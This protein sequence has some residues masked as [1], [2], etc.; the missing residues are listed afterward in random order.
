MKD[1]LSFCL[2]EDPQCR[3]DNFNIIENALNEIYRLSI[4]PEVNDIYLRSVP[5][6]VI[7]IFTEDGE[8]LPDEDSIPESSHRQAE[9]LKKGD[10]LLDVYRVEADPIATGGMGKIWR[11][12]HTGWDID[13]A[14][15]RPYPKL[16]KNENQK[17]NFIN[18]CEAWINLGLHPHIVSCY[19]VRE[20]EGVPSIFSEWMDGGSLHDWI[21]PQ[22]P[23]NEPRLYAG[24]PLASL[25]RILD[26]SIQVARGLGYVHER[27]DE[28]GNPLGLIHQDVK[29]D[30]L[31]L[32]LS[33]TVKVADFGI[34]RARACL[35]GQGQDVPAGAT[36]LAPS[37][38]YTPAY[39]SVE[40]ANGDMLTRRSDI[41]SWAVSVL[42]MFIG[43][44][45]W[46]SGVALSM[47]IDEFFSM[48]T[49]VKIPKKM[50]EL[51]RHCLMEDPNS[52]PRD[53]AEVEAELR[54]IYRLSVGR[55][56]ARALQSAAQD[57]AGS[58][59]NQALSM[60]D[61]G[62]EI[63][64]ENRWKAAIK[65]DPNHA[66]SQFNYALHLWRRGKISN[67]EAFDRIPS[68]SSEA[69]NFK[70]N[71]LLESGN[72]RDALALLERAEEEYGMDDSRANIYR[73]ISEIEART[74]EPITFES[75]EHDYKFL[76]IG[77][78]LNQALYVDKGIDGVNGVAVRTAAGRRLSWHPRPPGFDA[79]FGGFFVKHNDYIVAWA[80]HSPD[81]AIL[82]DRYLF[83]YYSKD[84]EEPVLSIPAGGM[85]AKLVSGHRTGLYGF[86]VVYDSPSKQLELYRLVP[87]VTNPVTKFPFDD[88]IGAYV[89]SDA[90]KMLT[91]DTNKVTEIGQKIFKV[92][93]WKIENT[94]LSMLY[95]ITLPYL[96]EK[97]NIYDINFK[98]DIILICKSDEKNHNLLCYN[99]KN[100][101]LIF[102]Y[103]DNELYF[104]TSLYDDIIF[105]VNR[106]KDIYSLFYMNI[107]NMQLKFST[108]LNTYAYGNFFTGDTIFINTNNEFYT[109][110]EHILF[111]NSF[112]KM[113][114]EFYDDKEDLE[115]V[116]VVFKKPLFIYKSNWSLSQ[117]DESL[118]I[119]SINKKFSKYFDNAEQEYKI[120]N[121]TGVIDNLKLATSLKGY[122][123][124]FKCKVLQ[125]KIRKFCNL[126]GIKNIQKRFSV[127]IPEVD[128][129][130][131]S[132]TFVP[133][134][135]YISI[136]TGI[137]GDSKP[138]WI[139]DL[140]SGQCAYN[141]NWEH[142]KY[143]M[144]GLSSY[145]V[146]DNNV[147]ALNYLSWSPNSDI[148]LNQ[149]YIQYGDS[150]L[151]SDFYPAIYGIS[152]SLDE[153]LY[154][155]NFTNLPMAG[156]RPF[157]KF[158]IYRDNE[159]IYFKDDIE[160][161]SFIDFSMDN[162]YIFIYKYLNIYTSII[163][164]VNLK[165][166]TTEAQYPESQVMRFLP[167]GRTALGLN[168]SGVICQYDLF[169]KI[170]PHS[171]SDK[172]L[173]HKAFDISADGS[174][175]VAIAGS[176]IYF[177]DIASAALLGKIIFTEGVPLQVRLNGN[178]D[179]LAVLTLNGAVIYDI[180]WELAFPGWADWDEG[181]RP[182]LDCFLRR[183]PDYT[184]DDFGLLM[185]T[186]QN[187]GYGWLKPES[188]RVKLDEA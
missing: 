151:L 71:I 84:D 13:L 165:S 40:Q 52:R 50:K 103:Q 181:A 153:R 143:S 149:N 188:V 69:L 106:K 70:A 156:V 21:Y 77:P 51:L 129:V 142:A 63:D 60:L 59:N 171:C 10:L 83:C 175:V 134:F 131:S 78:G 74:V 61:L 109:G 6:N 114:K 135:G 2:K 136:Y 107:L 137:Y 104:A 80:S 89:N 47:D 161:Y 138:T 28:N 183:C 8:T 117:I 79:V 45:S 49:R 90:S 133:R 128:K 81:S 125:A 25:E 186:L 102:E 48:E 127:A 27:V 180:E 170:S 111:K 169:G 3:P 20:I 160:N 72:Y 86:A 155:I 130:S 159:V 58:L 73:W 116:C 67:I 184:D 99:L 168:R 87:G 23:G 121:I 115:S 38:G 29:P 42:E 19:Y 64:A 1:L 177:W 172:S 167:N 126:I 37:G 179:T 112:D 35:S 56:Y 148:K 15:K 57:T 154:A 17:A 166:G 120:M 34:A 7:D 12:R 93:L 54:E 88:L 62:K 31:L 4:G 41:Y 158:K 9:G 163:E 94:N 162:D 100:G 39:C 140:N 145:H 53:F 43:G 164:L 16:F 98:T 185:E 150:K 44:R 22:G 46:L 96:T 101:S 182:Y 178:A 76:A 144:D 68:T 66:E 55:E 14:L 147:R 97:I 187:A 91:Y 157:Y 113:A 141:L 105:F 85:S 173:S 122:N 26:I 139:F 124:N 108:I 18:E 152:F 24:G 11:V 32:T 123:Y 174:K 119:I 118:E 132:I 30:N 5:P 65:I 33:G 146:A 110:N 176:D 36:M 92:K 82:E 95:E 75:S